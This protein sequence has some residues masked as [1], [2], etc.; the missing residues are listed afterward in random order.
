MVCRSSIKRGGFCTPVFIKH[1]CKITSFSSNYN[2]SIANIHYF[3][4]FLIT[5]KCKKAKANEI[6]LKTILESN[7]NTTECKKIL[8]KKFFRCSSD[9]S[10]YQTR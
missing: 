5:V 3:Y 4:A 10:P 7:Q 2:N 6:W 8:K 1:V 9:V